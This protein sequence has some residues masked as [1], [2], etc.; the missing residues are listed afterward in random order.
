MG[1]SV[2]GKVERVF[3]VRHCIPLLY[4]GIAEGNEGRIAAIDVS[5]TRIARIYWPGR[6]ADDASSSGSRDADYADLVRRDADYADSGLARDADDADSSDRR[7]ADYADRQHGTADYA[8]LIG[9]DGTRMTGILPLARDA[10]TGRGSR[11]FPTGCD[12]RN[13]RPVEESA[14]SASRQEKSARSASRENRVIASRAAIAISDYGCGA[15]CVESR[16]DTR[17]GCPRSSYR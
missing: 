9:L 1:K 16:P 11:R 17:P 4:F 3:P 5:G 6:D 10:G 13:P 12:P 14:R 15:P 2:R 7:D 8:D